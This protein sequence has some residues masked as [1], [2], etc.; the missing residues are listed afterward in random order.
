MTIQMT[1]PG[2]GKTL[3]APDSFA[4][5]RAKCKNC[6]TAMTIGGGV[7]E[8]VEDLVAV[9]DAEEVASVPASRVDDADDGSSPRRR[10][11]A[12][13]DEELDE[14]EAPRRSERPRRRRKRRQSSGGS[15][16][17]IALI[18]G[19]VVLFLLVLIGGGGFAGWYFIFK[20]TSPLA[21]EKKYLPDSIS[22]IAIIQVDKIK[23]SP[24]YAEMSKC[25]K[26]KDQ[27]AFAKTPGGKDLDVVRAVVVVGQPIA[28]TILTMRNAPAI[29]DIVDADAQI[30][31]T[32]EN[33]KTMYTVG[34]QA[35]FIDGKRVVIATPANLKSILNPSHEATV[36]DDMKKAL[37]ISDFSKPM[38]SIVSMTEIKKRLLG[39][40]PGLATGAQEQFPEVVSVEADFQL[41]MKVQLKLTCKDAAVANKA[42]EEARMPNSFKIAGGD[43]EVKDSTVIVSK[44]VPSSE[45]CSFTGGM[46]VP[47]F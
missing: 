30:A 4:G 19:C 43:V 28:V 21:G 36:P 24:A 9:V 40:R 11:R 14:D 13:D 7:G 34:Q 12:R 27:F 2:C 16:L 44:T 38:V 32:K 6:E 3:Q 31:E 18:I 37:A 35:Y 10:T 45:L 41:P 15:G 17:K 8:V 1:C 39:G 33:G 26:F 42:A 29:K 47:N 25:P 46:A 23:S 22:M 5:K 20:D